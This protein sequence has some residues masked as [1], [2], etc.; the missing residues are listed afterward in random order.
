MPALKMKSKV[1][2]LMMLN[3]WEECTFEPNTLLEVE[4]EP[5]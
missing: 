5:P 3:I 2:R 4:N 1:K